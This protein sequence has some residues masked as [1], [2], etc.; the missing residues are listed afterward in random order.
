MEKT[1]KTVLLALLT[2]LVLLAGAFAVAAYL[3]QGENP[4]GGG[5]HVHSF[6]EWAT[7]K[8]A[9]CTEAG[10]K[11]RHCSCGET[12]TTPLPATGHTLQFLEP[13]SPTCTETGLSAGEYC[14]VCN[15]IT[16]EQTVTESFGHSYTSTVVYPTC[17]SEGYTVYECRNCKDSYNDEYTK[18]KEHSI[19]S[20]GICYNCET[21]FSVA[22]ADRFG[23]VDFSWKAYFDRFDRQ[24]VDATINMTNLSGKQVKYLSVSLLYENAVGDTVFTCSYKF[25]GPYDA[26]QNIFEEMTIGDTTF[27]FWMKVTSP[28]HTIGN[29]KVGQINIEYFDGTTEVCK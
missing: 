3:G 10:L 4:L 24:F 28:G 7:A 8:S 14:S 16:K 12:Q 9:T 22:I 2:I 20:N 26:G 21:D 1:M 18:K 17:T 5:S 15:T 11:K 29:V 25:T 6:G 19:N 27:S 23:S 13:I